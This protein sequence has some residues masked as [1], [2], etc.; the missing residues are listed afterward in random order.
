MTWRREVFELSHYLAYVRPRV[1]ESADQYAADALSRWPDLTVGE[2][3]AAIWFAAH[4][5]AS[6]VGRTP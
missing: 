4:C 6:R 2:I 5:D 1:G 3:Q